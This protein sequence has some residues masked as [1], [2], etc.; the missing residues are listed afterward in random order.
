MFGVFPEYAGLRE[1]AEVRRALVEA[2]LP[3]R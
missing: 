1:Q 2:G 3:V